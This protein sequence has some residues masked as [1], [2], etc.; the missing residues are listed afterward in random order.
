[1][2]AEQ[3]A[4]AGQTESADSADLA[5]FGYKQELK[6]Q[7][8]LGSVWAVAFSYISP[9][10]GIFTLFALGLTTLGGVF[11]WTWPVV[12]LGQFIVALNFAEVTSHYP[13]A[14]S[15]FQWTKYLSGRTYSWFNGWIYLFAGILTVTAVV[16]TI[17]L[18]LIPALNGL[19]WHSLN[20]AS[21][22]TQLLVALITLVVITVLNIYGVRLVAIINNTGV[23]F[24]I[25]GMFV[26][27]L[28]LLAFHN[29]QGLHVVTN[30]G[31]VPVTGSTFLAAMFMSLFVIYGFDTASTLAEETRDPRRAAPK[32]VLYA[33]VGAFI[34]GG[35]FLLGTLV[36]IPAHL[37][38]KGA[39]AANGGLGLAPAQIIEAN[40]SSAFATIYLLVVSAAIFVCCLSIMAATIRL[41]FGMSRD[42][43]LPISKVLSK[44]SPKLHTP[45]W[46][47]IVIAVIAAIPF[48]QY[49]GAGIIAIAATGTIYISYFLGNIIIMRA[50]ARGWPRTAAPFRLGRWGMLVNI[51]ALIY[52]GAMIINFA[53]PRAASN[54]K[55]NQTGGLLDFHIS[56]LNG[57]P[58]LWT[59]FVV[60]VVIGVIYYLAAGRRKEFAP[61]IAPAGDDAPLV[62]ERGSAKDG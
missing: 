52:G 58:I 39:M 14:G 23:V 15:V 18:A 25:L 7:L 13:I 32:A 53:W 2:S 3:S 49:S 40:F 4:T 1:M 10:T 47:C 50:R 17:P 62:T 35:V 34:I 60:I 55:P 43:T 56:F 19:G 6:R 54:P 38:V 30:S 8:G 41:C 12:A 24:E 37:G 57:I 26:F 61:S 45:V 20:A 27:A 36:A 28:V 33:V 16:A 21:L 11:I 59:V 9:S 5:Q 42:N 51:L 29:H 44:V 48:L 22:H 46:T 31:G